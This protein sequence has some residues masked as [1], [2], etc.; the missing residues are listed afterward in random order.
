MMISNDESSRGDG[1]RGDAP[2]RA[3][4]SID[5]QRRERDRAALFVALHAQHQHR[6]AG[7]VH[8]LVLSWHDAEEIVQNTSVVLWR[9]FDEYDPQSNFFAWAAS[10]ARYEILNYQRANRRRM[11]ITLD[12]EVLE[13]LAPIAVERLEHLDLQRE[14]LATCVEQLPAEDRRLLV[15]RYEEGGST[16]EVATL[17]GRT[18]GHAQRVLRRIRALLQRCVQRRLAEGGN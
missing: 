17:L 2:R 15:A 8:T 9:K 12:D 3:E 11:S 10:I 14:A 16:R 7:F 1:S 18:S 4:A 13:S 5:I 6:I